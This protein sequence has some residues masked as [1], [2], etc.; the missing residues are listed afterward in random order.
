M[1]N[2][3]TDL[4]KSALE[5]T[6]GIVEAVPVYK[7]AIQPAA[8]EVGKALTT[9][10][11]TVN[12]ALAPLSGLVWGYEQVGEYLTNRLSQIL[13]DTP[14]EKVVAPDPSIACPAIEQ[15]RITAGKPDLREMYAKLV[16][17]AMCL[18]N[19]SMAH[20]AFVETIKQM[21]SDEAKIMALLADR[22]FLPQPI[23]TLTYDLD[24][25]RFPGGM[26]LT[27]QRNVS[28]LTVEAGCSSLQPGPTCLD[29][30]ARLR[31]IRLEE[32]TPTSDDCYTALVNSEPV[33]KHL[34]VQVESLR[35]SLTRGRVELTDFGQLFIDACLLEPSEVEYSRRHGRLPNSPFPQ[36]GIPRPVFR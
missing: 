26:Y 5:M 16:A 13:K 10:A 23:V 14:P 19:V 11:K 15:L 20:P 31:L 9:L 27:R 25:S 6:R 30:L 32:H 21:T 29:N 3:K 12:L 22:R 8:K 24:D 35:P 7:D 4:A 36:E 2:D 33:K 34:A 28:L 17:S 1:S 18:D